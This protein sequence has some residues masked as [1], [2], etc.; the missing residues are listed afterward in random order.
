MTM[1]N[2][3]V[4]IK[5]T[6]V[7]L[8]GSATVVT[9][10]DLIMSLGGICT[11]FNSTVQA[12]YSAIK[13]VRVKIRAS[14]VEQ[15]I[16]I[17]KLQW[18]SDSSFFRPGYESLVVS[19]SASQPAAI[20][21]KPPA[22]SQAAQWAQGN[23]GNLFYVSGQDNTTGGSYAGPMV[24]EVDMLAVPGIV[25]SGPVAPTTSVSTGILG[26]IYCLGLTADAWVPQG[27]NYTT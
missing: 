4:A 1:P 6:Y 14:C 15:S 19:Q 17:I 22:G 16:S 21:Q 2:R 5:R 25:P 24:M 9:S 10:N 13:I 8:A 12:F 26:S 7:N 11:I 23:T 27:V 20:D 3:P 18:L